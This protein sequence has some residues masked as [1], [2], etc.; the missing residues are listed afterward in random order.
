VSGAPLIVGAAVDAEGAVEGAVVGV[1]DGIVVDGVDGLLAGAAGVEVW[2]TARLAPSMV[3]RT[4]AKVVRVT[5]LL[6]LSVRAGFI[7]G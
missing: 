2:A 1:V 6:L 3:A 7:S 4:A 5:S